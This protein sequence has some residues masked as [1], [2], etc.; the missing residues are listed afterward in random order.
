MRSFSRASAASQLDLGLRGG[1][2]ARAVTVPAGR[3]VGGLAAALPRALGRGRAL[4]VAGGSDE[5]ARG[6]VSRRMGGCKDGR[7]ALDAAD[8]G[9]DAR[10][11][12]RGRPLPPRQQ[13][14][15][16]STRPRCAGVGRRRARAASVRSMPHRVSLGQWSLRAYARPNA[17]G[18][19]G[20]S[21]RAV[22]GDAISPA[23]SGGPRAAPRG[24]RR[25]GSSRPGRDARRRARRSRRPARGPGQTS[26]PPWPPAP[27]PPRPR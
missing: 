25:P 18:L 17:S 10:V 16:G 15:R 13:A 2:L 27:P 20:G 4:R 1:P 8:L 19:P 21:R 11:E 9:S 12:A 6:S 14:G 23:W 22:A 7:S 5:R 24:R 3:G 26:R